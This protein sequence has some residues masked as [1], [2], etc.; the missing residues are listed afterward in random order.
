MV[1]LVSAA[2]G[3]EKAAWGKNEDIDIALKLAAEDTLPELNVAVVVT[4]DDNACAIRLAVV[5]ENN[6]VA[7]DESDCA[8][9]KALLGVNIVVEAEVNEA[10]VLPV[11]AAN[12]ATDVEVELKDCA[13]IKALLG[14]NIETELLENDS[15]RPAVPTKV[16]TEED[17]LEKDCEFKSPETTENCVVD[18]ALKAAASVAGTPPQNP[19]PQPPDP[20]PLVTAE[21]SSKSASN[22]PAAKVVSSNHP[23]GTSVASNSPFGI[24][25]VYQVTTMQ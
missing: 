8:F 6:A 20:Q 13:F 16:A 25:T 2:D 11:G 24:A 15:R 12:D 22:H 23:A 5:G 1:E 21:T 18:V 4:V 10:D 17:V 14:V 3:V 9:S 19:L 7:L